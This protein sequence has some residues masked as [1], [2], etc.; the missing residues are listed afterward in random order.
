MS[1]NTENPTSF[2]I[3]T[4]TKLENAGREERIK[5]KYAI[6]YH[7]YGGMGSYVYLFSNNHSIE[8]CETIKKD[9]EPLGYQGI[10]EYISKTTKTCNLVI[11]D[12]EFQ[13]IAVF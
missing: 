8:E 7:W 10:K 13:T 11:M 9:I 1:I 12:A 2:I 6:C 3:H 5:E 4:N